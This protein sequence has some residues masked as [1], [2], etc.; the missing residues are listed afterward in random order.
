MRRIIYLTILLSMLCVKAYS[1]PVVVQSYQSPN[2]VSVTNLE[3][4]QNAIVN[5]INSADGA[6][7]QAGT[8]SANA[9][10]NNANPEERWGRAFNDWVFEG[11][12][13]PTSGSL[14][15]TTTAGS[16]F[17]TNATNQQKF[18]EKD[19]T[20]NTY[21]ATK[22][23]YIDLSSSGTYTYVESTIDTAEP[24][25][26]ANSLRLSRVSTDGTTVT[27]V[28]DDRTTSISLSVS[29]DQ[30][31]IGFMLTVATPAALT[32]DPG[33]VYHGTTRLEKTADTT[34]AL[35]TGT[36]WATGSSQR[37]TSTYG[38]VVINDAGTIKLST[39]AP[40]LTDT[41]ANTAGTLRYSVI[42]TVNWRVLNWFFMNANG[43]GDIDEW[44]YS[45]FKDGDI[46]NSIQVTAD[47][48][49]STTS[50]SFTDL[51]NMSVRFVST[52]RPV[53]IQGKTWGWI[54]Q[55]ESKVQITIDVDGTEKDEGVSGAQG[56][57][58]G[59]AI[60]GTSST[61]NWVE[62]LSAGTHTIKLQWRVS[63][64]TGH[65]VKRTLTVT[66]H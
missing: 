58:D 12:T 4:N 51:D 49:T 10:T 62:A 6:L 29:E 32:V 42:S 65:S 2:D 57:N 24:A 26:T 20:A 18:V 43:S 15:A 1:A 63:A 36:D 48:G 45:G 41:L 30:H 9:L 37:A 11:L 54:A 13:T 17:I 61:A 25:V 64:S 56:T 27:A 39:T 50:T 66:E 16:A 33:V 53:K 55:N 5:G 46:A 7:I 3:N 52:G 35:G 23:T 19:A 47:A 44:G 31:R 40:T 34:L 8:I 59:G 22:W 21:T 28:R 14:T 38:Y 60:H